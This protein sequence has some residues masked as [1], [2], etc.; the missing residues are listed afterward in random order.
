MKISR[1]RSRCVAVVTSAAALPALLPVDS[2]S[3]TQNAPSPILLQPS[4]LADLKAGYNALSPGGS[5]AELRPGAKKLAERV[6][7]E[8]DAVADAPAFTITKNREKFL[9]NSG[10]TDAR[11]FYSTAP[12]YWPDPSKP[13]GLPYI[14]RDGE[15][16]PERNRISDQSELNRLLDA[17]SFL[18]V[19]YHMTGKERYAASAARLL[20]AFFLDPKTRMNPNMTHAQAVLGVNTGRSI[21]IIDTLPFSQL[22]DCI[23]LLS[24]SPS[25]TPEDRAAMRSWWRE[26]AGWLQGSAP[27]KE[28]GAAKNNHGTNYDLQLA[29]VLSGAGDL[30]GIRR[31]LGN[32]V[33]A[34]MDTQIKP[35]GQQPEE[36]ARRTSWHYCN[37]NL[38]S[39]CKLAVMARSVG[40]DLWSHQAPDGG[41]SL[42]KA[43]RFLIPFLDHPKEWKF[44]EISD[45]SNEGARP[46]LALGAVA[47]DDPVIRDAQK[48]FAPLETLDLFDWLSVPDN[49]R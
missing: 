40:I 10:V 11:D 22:P 4:R 31:V 26:F 9:R 20:R 18:T 48:T 19:A 3:E 34:R 45:F 23:S 6:V 24:P 46:W 36:E 14:R 12:Y 8:A 5:A 32:S 49:S 35:D 15:H 42:N 13:D 1:I 44:Q 41:G 39:L 37:F 7:K 29:G 27:G 47:Y 25:W 33:P 43:M 2:F 28:E 21:G 16:N 38:R 17:V 30:E